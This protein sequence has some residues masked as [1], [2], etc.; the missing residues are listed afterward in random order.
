[1]CVPPWRGP[2]PQ[3]PCSSHEQR[4]TRTN[5]AGFAHAT[6]RHAPPTT[7]LNLNRPSN[8][9]TVASSRRTPSDFLGSMNL[10]VR[11]FR[12]DL[13]P[14][15]LLLLPC[16][17]GLAP[18]SR[19]RYAPSSTGRPPLQGAPTLP[20]AESTEVL[21]LPSLQGVGGERRSVRVSGRPVLCCA[22]VLCPQGVCSWCPHLPHTAA[23]VGSICAP[24]PSGR[25]RGGSSAGAQAL[26]VRAPDKHAQEEQQQQQQQE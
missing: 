9:S 19:M 17:V 14:P 5:Q 20:R 2:A 23:R 7:A 1:M 25:R 13:P 3:Q 12:F 21:P 8:T 24:C 22:P 10:R 15:L 18:S 16:S 4:H 11:R 26:G 6:K